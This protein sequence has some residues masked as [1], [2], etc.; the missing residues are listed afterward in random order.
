MGIVSLVRSDFEIS[1]EY[2]TVVPPLIMCTIL[3]LIHYEF[4][5]NIQR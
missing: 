5:L 4:G 2:S 3:N 1:M